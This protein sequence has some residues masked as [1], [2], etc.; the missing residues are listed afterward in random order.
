MAA[1]AMGY[2][3]TSTRTDATAGDARPVASRR[4]GGYRLGD[5]LFAFGR[6][7]TV[8]GGAGDRGG[9]DA[10]ALGFLEFSPR[11]DARLRVVI[12]SARGTMASIGCTGGA[13]DRCLPR[14]ALARSRNSASQT[15]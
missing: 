11:Y 9:F 15:I 2:R 5:V 12:L 4:T 3:R 1:G 7:A 10:C 6:A 14:P 8:G 13:G